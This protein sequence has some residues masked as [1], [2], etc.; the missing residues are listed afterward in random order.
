[1]RAGG[2]AK[3]L[4]VDA[5]PLTASIGFM[6]KLK[7]EFHLGDVLRDWKRMDEDLWTRL[8]VAVCGMDVILAPESPTS[9]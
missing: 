7:S 8:T 1:M 6:L 9:E 3:V 5:D 4:L 2:E